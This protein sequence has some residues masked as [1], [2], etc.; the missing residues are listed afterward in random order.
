MFRIDGPYVVG[1]LPPTRQGVSSPGYFG[2]GDPA[3]GLQSTRVTYEWLNAVQEELAGVIQA[4]GI[5]LDKTQYTQLRQALQATYGPPNIIAPG[6]GLEVDGEGKLIVD[7]DILEGVEPGTAAPKA[8]GTAT[9]GTSA[10]YAREDHV[11]PAQASVTGN[12][13]TA[14][15]LATAR[16]ITAKD[17]ATAGASFDGSKNVNV[18]IPVTVAAG[19]ATYA[20]PGT[21]T[22]SLRSWLSAARNCLDWL[23][24]RFN[25]AGQA[26]SAASATKLATPRKIATDLSLLVAKEF[27]GTVPVT[28]GITGVLGISN[29]GTGA[30]T[31]AAART[32]LGITAGAPIPKEAA[33]VGQW[34]YVYHPGGSYTLP[35]G[36]TWAY[37]L[38]GYGTVDNPIFKGVAAGVAAG[39]TAI[40]PKDI[41]GLGG[42]N[43]MRGFCWRVA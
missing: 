14:T 43:Q 11:H 28:T 39:G 3:T 22:M 17:D 12:A 2:P 9:A 29:G 40:S 4:A 32:A 16:T 25:T 36:G 8:P 1:S 5:S 35:A 24:A 10:K 31:A 30:T 13:G 23:Q 6:G 7:P 19:T 27:D 21:A 42:A 18:G 41:I 38:S 20:L 33:G 15:K 37:F 26:V 34:L